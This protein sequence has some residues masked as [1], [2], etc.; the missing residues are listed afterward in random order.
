M[1]SVSQ[2]GP[3]GQTTGFP[4]VC[5]VDIDGFRVGVG[6]KDI[7]DIRPEPCPAG[8]WP[9]WTDLVVAKCGRRDF[10]TH[11]GSVRMG[12]AYKAV[13][14]RADDCQGGP[15]DFDVDA[16]SL[17]IPDPVPSYLTPEEWEALEPAPIEPPSDW[18]GDASVGWMSLPPISGG[19]DEAEP[20]EADWRAACTMF[21]TPEPFTPSPD[22]LA[23]M[24][25]HRDATECMHGYE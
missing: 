2:R 20:S 4:M 23:E 3:L 24:H 11:I 17:P 7:P 21:R 8:S 1:Q 25:S 5:L 15:D 18:P 10:D 6:E 12:D 13:M 22:D 9:R 19:S 14:E 16:G